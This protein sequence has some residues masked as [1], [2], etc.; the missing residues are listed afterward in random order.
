MRATS[1]VLAA[2]VVAA[3]VAL[4]LG[5]DRIAPV[6]PTA[7]PDVAPGEPAS[8]G[9]WYCAAGDTVG[10][11]ELLLI[12]AAAPSE[13][14][15][16]GQTTTRIFADGAFD[17]ARSGNVFPGS[18]ALDTIADGVAEAGIATRWWELP[19]A[20]SRSWDVSAEG[21]V[22]G[23]VSGPCVH[24]PSA[25]WVV[26]GMATAGGAQ[27]V[28]HLANPFDSDATV[29]ITLTTPEG[30]LAPRRLENV[31]VPRRSVERIELNE[32][33]PEQTDL[34]VIVATRAG[35]VVA[36][37]VQSF[38]AAI[39][40]VEGLSLAAAAA[41]PAEFWTIPWFA[42]DDSRGSWLW[43]TNPG[44]RSAAVEIIVHTDEG[45]IVPD[46][47]EE[48]TL[49]PGTV[50]RIDLRG[51]LPE[52]ADHGA[53]TV[54][55]DN[56]QPIAASVATQILAEAAVR[57]GVAVQLGSP[58]TDHTWILSGGPTEGRDVT[59]ELVNPGGDDAVVDLALWG[60]GG[61]L[62]PAELREVDVPAG[63]AVTVDLTG[64][65]PVA[66]SYSVFVTARDGGQ[67][68]AAQIATSRGDGPLDAVASVGVPIGRLTAGGT[69]P[70]ITFSPGMPQRIGTELGPHADDDPFATSGGST[71]DDASG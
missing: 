59:V 22:S 45:G 24:E 31:V 57:S 35:R 12:T 65:L 5:L 11:S 40:G 15:H 70:P 10:E 1:P 3:V 36:E 37:G 9:A 28:L 47:L 51:L 69:V 18:A 2:V 63:A 17:D 48:L 61:V 14:G 43:I 34:G 20:V 54:R 25:R 7:A 33:A 58:V 60:G 66:A 55:S 30:V 19:I 53:L 16:P 46:G 42:D 68:A 4:G 38:N 27:A 13:D 32:H 6:A 67:V 8:S 49:D 23:V 64:H 52:G 29:A 56:S 41:E 39:G 44:E 71:G 26:P 21:G 62:R 50:R